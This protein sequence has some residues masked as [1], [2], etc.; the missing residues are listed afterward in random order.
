[1]PTSSQ[2]RQPISLVLGDL[3]QRL[4]LSQQEAIA[5]GTR[6]NVPLIYA[7]V[8]YV[9]MQVSLYDIL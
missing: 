9:G 2:T 8:L 5:A 7:L 1:M 3:K 6:Y 4:M